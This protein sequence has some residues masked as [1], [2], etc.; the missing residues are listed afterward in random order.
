MSKTVSKKKH[1]QFWNVTPGLKDIYLIKFFYSV[2]NPF[3]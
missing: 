1:M 2:V 3:C